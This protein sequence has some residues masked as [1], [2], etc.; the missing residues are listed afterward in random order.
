MKVST[1]RRIWRRILLA[2][3]FCGVGYGFTLIPGMVMEYTVK[4]QTAERREAAAPPVSQAPPAAPSRQTE[5]SPSAPLP[6]EPAATRA[7]TMESDQPALASDPAHEAIIQALKTVIDPE[8]GIN[9]VDLGLIRDIADHG[10][11]GLT[12]T[13]IPTSPLCPYLKQL[14]AAIKTKVGHLAVQQKVQV[15]VDMKH[16]WTPDN[17]SAAGRRHFFG[18]KP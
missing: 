16:R 2:L 6:A 3:L 8:L 15:T 18:S 10:A 9:I 4:R 14:V 13:M 11:E 5:Q 7:E 1:A 12:I 17:L